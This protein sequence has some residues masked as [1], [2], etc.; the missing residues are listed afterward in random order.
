MKNFYKNN[1]QMSMLNQIKKSGL[2]PD[3]IK[4]TNVIPEHIHHMKAPLSLLH[5]H[6]PHINS[7]TLTVLNDKDSLKQ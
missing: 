3:V 6:R 5:I 2:R 4:V 1:N 7:I